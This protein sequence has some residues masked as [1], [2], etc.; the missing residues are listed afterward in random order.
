MDKEQ[1]ETGS[2]AKKRGE[3]DDQIGKLEKNNL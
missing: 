3:Q 2:V 1:E